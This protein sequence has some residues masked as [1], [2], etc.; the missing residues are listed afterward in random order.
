MK[1]IYLKDE[2]G[3]VYFG[4]W[5]VIVCGLIGAFAYGGAVTVSGVFLLPVTSEL[6][7]AIGQFSL[8]LS[9]MSI[10]NIV[11]LFFISKH[12]TEKHTKKI[13]LAAGCCGA[14]AFTGFSFANELWQFYALAVPM[15]LCFSSMTMTPCTILVSNW[16]GPG[17]RGKAMSYFLG[18]MA[19]VGIPLLNVLNYLIMKTGWRNGYLL[20]AAGILV[21]LPLTAKFAVW[22]PAVKGIRR[23]GELEGGPSINPEH[24]PG[25]PFKEGRKNPWLWLALITCSFVVVAS[26]AVLQHGIPTMILAGYTPVQATGIVSILSA[27]IIVTGLIVGALT[28]KMGIFFVAVGTCVMFAIGL[29]GHAFLAGGGT[30]MLFVLIIGYVFGVPAVNVIPPLMMSN[31][32]GERELGRYIG[33]VNI[34]IAFGGVFGAALV[35]MLFDAFGGYREPWL[36]A[37][38]ILLLAGVIRGICTSKRHRFVPE[39]VQMT[40]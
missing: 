27:V 10:T 24:V 8:Y 21:C 31:M 37:A 12:F 5:I 14:L 1:S 35:G 29:V 15:G 11:T 32:F 25:I 36:V 13:M 38:G 34:F 7:F 4:W 28:D 33:Y 26:S 20:I 23:M 39:K 30:V 6:G 22:S 3:K 19:L 40:E 2:N 9:I 17:A 18:I 16:F